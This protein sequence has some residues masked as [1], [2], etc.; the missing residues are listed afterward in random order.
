MSV[1]A[2]K[3]K[4]SSFGPASSQEA[5]SMRSN[6]SSKFWDS[7]CAAGSLAASLLHSRVPTCCLCGRTCAQMV[8]L[9]RHTSL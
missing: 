5:K 6:I 8:S 3:H 7:L 9:C 4:I 1:T 2:S